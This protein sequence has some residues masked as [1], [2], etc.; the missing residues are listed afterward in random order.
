MAASR[1]GKGAVTDD[2]TGFRLHRAL[3]PWILD[4]TEAHTIIN[5]LAAAVRDADGHSGQIRSAILDA[6][7]RLRP[8]L[9]NHVHIDVAIDACRALLDTSGEKPSSIGTILR[10][11]VRAQQREFLRK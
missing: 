8:L 1:R 11:Y 4:G 5:D 2:V 9:A 6:Q 7:S 3:T 10:G